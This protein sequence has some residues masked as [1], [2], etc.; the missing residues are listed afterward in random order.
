MIPEEDA[1]ATAAPLP[2]PNASSVYLHPQLNSNGEILKN[3]ADAGFA[4]LD[5]HTRQWVQADAGNRNDHT[6]SGEPGALLLG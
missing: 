4:R 3:N 2:D 1:W 6:P 5:P